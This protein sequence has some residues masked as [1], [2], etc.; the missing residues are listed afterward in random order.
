MVRFILK[1]SIHTIIFTNT[2]ITLQL[3]FIVNNNTKPLE[4]YQSKRSNCFLSQTSHTIIQTYSTYCPPTFVPPCISCI[5][6]MLEIYFTKKL[7]CVPQD[8][9]FRNQLAYYYLL[10]SWLLSVLRDRIT[11]ESWEKDGNFGLVS[12]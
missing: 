2:I 1:L 11:R 12:N 8:N 6:L 3:N 4:F 10:P 9:K 5:N 7:V